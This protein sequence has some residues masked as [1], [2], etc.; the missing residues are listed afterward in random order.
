LL[1]ALTL[2]AYVSRA[3]A[4]TITS[5]TSDCSNV[6]Q[7]L[8]ASDSAD[9]LGVT[10]SGLVH[11]EQ[12]GSGTCTTTWEAETT[13][14]LL[15]GEYVI[16]NLI[17]FLYDLTGGSASSDG[18]ALLEWDFRAELLNTSANIGTS[19]SIDVPGSGSIFSDFDTTVFDPDIFYV[20]E[21]G[22]Y[23]IRQTA[24]LDL[25]LTGGGSIVADLDFPVTSYMKAYT[26]SAVPD[27]VSILSTLAFGLGL[28][29]T[30]FRKLRP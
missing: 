30:G 25:I 5:F 24:V 8:S 9:P 1:V 4:A 20:L 16:G 10:V 11:M 12:V 17:D 29:A 27:P 22:D 2:A 18:D 21:E 14:H 23:V 26:P 15:A 6:S 7:S 3:D 19:S 28:L 13:I